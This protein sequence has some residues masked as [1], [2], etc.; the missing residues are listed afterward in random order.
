M[1]NLA[2]LAVITC[3]HIVSIIILDSKCQQKNRQ[4]MIMVY[5]GGVPELVTE[6]REIGAVLL[7]TAEKDLETAINGNKAAAHKEF[8]CLD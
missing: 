7:C 3:A 4:R 5:S 6:S 2:V 8:S 1:Q